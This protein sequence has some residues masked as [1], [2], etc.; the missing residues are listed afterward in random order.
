M[1]YFNLLDTSS[2]IFENLDSFALSKYKNIFLI[3]K[4]KKRI[5]SSQ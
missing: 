4:K 3:I 1:K 2:D 5:S